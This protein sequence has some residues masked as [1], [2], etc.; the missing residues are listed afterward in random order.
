MAEQKGLSAAALKYIALAAM[1]T[2][3]IGWVFFPNMTPVSFGMHVVG[4]LTAP[5]MCYFI[6]EGYFYTHDLKRY[7]A[8]L[9]T[10]AAVSHAAYGLCFYGKPFY[11]LHTGVM[12]TLAVGLAALALVQRYPAGDAR[13]MFGVLL[14]FVL[15]MPGDWS[16]YAVAWIVWFGNTHGDRRAQLC[17]LALIGGVFAVSNL[18]AGIGNLFQFGVL[19]AVP[20]LKRYNGQR[21]A[22]HPKAL[23]YWFY[24]VHLLLLAAVKYF[25][26]G[27]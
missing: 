6:A 16:V 26:T 14:C 23:F 19:L 12:W 17:G 18:T 21:G 15:A 13:R 10:G 11:G 27:F 3:H 25:T 8:R 22:H 9:L 2:D 4:R 20:L 24:P 7:F 1:L 5:I